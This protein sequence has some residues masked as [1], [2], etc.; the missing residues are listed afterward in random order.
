MSS[1]AHV[2]RYN[3]L[4]RFGLAN[5]ISEKIAEY[6]WKN[7][8][9]LS[10]VR[11]AKELLIACDYGG[12][13]KNALY[14]S[15]AFL[16]ANISDSG[17][18]DEQRNLLRSTVLTEGRRISFKAIRGKKSITV[19]NRFLKIANFLPGVLISFLIDKKLGRL[20]SVKKDP[21]KFFEL[22]YPKYGWNNYSFDRLSLV[23]HL[24]SLLIGGLC[25]NKQDILWVTDQD[26]IAPNPKKHDDA[27]WVIWS[28]LC[29]Y[30]PKIDGKL[31]FV[32][33]EADLGQRR[34]EDAVSIAD[35]SAGAWAEAMSNIRTLL[36]KD[37]RNIMIP[38]I[39]NFTE[40]TDKILTWFSCNKFPLSKLVVVLQCHENHQVSIKVGGSCI[41]STNSTD[42]IPFI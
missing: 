10:D 13:H 40:K 14:E 37:V 9:L 17:E 16:V 38:V 31:V 4:S 18:W 15:Y 21:Y 11:N 20:I 30:A 25:G 24:G 5:A 19:L 42:T 34:L 41:L 29:E 32:T 33:T 7:P 6:E 39:G 28:Y 3:N 23:A 36:Q 22:I 1:S 8:G 12:N 35:L 27:G 26:E 2:W